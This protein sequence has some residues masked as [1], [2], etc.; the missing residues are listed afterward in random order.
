MAAMRI[1]VLADIHGNILA[2]R[3]VL[4]DI[5]ARHIDLI[6]N[7]GDSVSGPLWPRETF[8]QLQALGAPTVRGNHD[9]QV[10]TLN[11]K[12]MGASD[13]FA[14]TELSADQR[15]ALGQL[16]FSRIF[17]P[18]IIGFHATPAHDDR[19]VVEDIADGHLIRA[20]I[21]KISKRLG[22]IDARI[23]LLGHSHQSSQVLL[24]SGVT[25]INPGSVGCP[26]YEDPTGKA[27]CSEAGT[28][29][30]RYAILDDG[31]SGN[32]AVTLCALPYPH[33]RAA[34]QALVN[35]RPEWAHALRT[36]FMPPKGTEC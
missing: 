32:P 11:Q 17:A 9:R 33:D 5:Q 4:A 3:S 2:L 6:V 8:E 22:V 23:V 10:A 36:G 12:S 29:H 25:I 28:P 26:A 19:Y 34:Q 18:G 20:P 7:L 31:G 30:A 35:G 24:P 15:D 1:A 16:P 13:R 14:Y 21:E 27:H